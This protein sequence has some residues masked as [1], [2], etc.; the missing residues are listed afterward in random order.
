MNN[1][2]FASVKDFLKRFKLPVFLF[3]I[4]LLL[5]IFGEKSLSFESGNVAS[6][7][8][9]TSEEAEIYTEH[10]EKKIKALLSELDGVS[11]VSVLLTLDGGNELVYAENTA[12]GAVDYLIINSSD[13]EEPVLIREIYSS[14]REIAV[15]C[16]GGDSA[17]TK[18]TI[19]ELL[20]SAFDLPYTKISVAG[21]E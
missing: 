16:K 21:A 15:V 11:D 8:K 12:S 20:S 13:G 1:E 4:G 14:V 18:R 19:T 10:L 2:A 7:D 6:V 5:I 3:A 9:S 17:N